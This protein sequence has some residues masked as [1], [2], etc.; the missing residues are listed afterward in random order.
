VSSPAPAPATTGID[1]ALRIYGNLSLLEMA[2]VL[3]GAD[4][5]YRGQA[6]IEHGGIMSLW[7]KDSDLA[8][9]AAHGRSHIAANSETQALRGSFENPD[10]RFIFAIAE[11]A[12]R[13][14]CR[15]SAGIARLI[16]L[17]GKRVGTMLKSSAQY[18][19]DRMLRTVGLSERD[20]SIVHHM[21]KTDTPLTLMP[22]ALRDGTLDAVTV[23][24][25]QIQKAYEMLGDDAIVF[26]DP[27]VYR[28]RFCLCTTAANLEDSTL[29]ASIVAFV[30][31]MIEA[32]GALQRDPRDA[33]MLVAVAANLDKKTVAHSW[34]YLTYPGSLAA[35]LLDAL[36]TADQW[37]A[38]ETGRAP[39]SANELR[40]QIDPGVL[41]EALG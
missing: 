14:V 28:E 6:V 35:D 41:R 27:S 2:P 3:L 34:P 15:R 1:T 23:W 21:A 33:Q 20:V 13:I 7:G 8:S 16:D 38:K 32:T 40:I 36:V 29:R 10:L 31:A 26:C 17:R 37:V 30:R 18:F 9:L 11:C 19:L 12:Y 5:F 4:R 22:T 39:R 25:P 24:E